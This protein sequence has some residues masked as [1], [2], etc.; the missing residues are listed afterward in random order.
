MIAACDIKYLISMACQKNSVWILL[1]EEEVVEEK[2]YYSQ[3]IYCIYL[4]FPHVSHC[5][6]SDTWFL[7]ELWFHPCG[8]S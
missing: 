3:Q 5:R 1:E 6:C 2:E 4:L 8:G 7:R